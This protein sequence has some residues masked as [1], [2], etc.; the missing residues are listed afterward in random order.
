MFGPALRTRKSLNG[1]VN[2]TSLTYPFTESAIRTLSV[3]DAVSLNGLIYTGRDRL[4]KFLFDGGESPVDLHDGAIYHCG[5]VMAK[6]GRGWRVV[7]AGPTTSLREEPYM[8]RIIERCG[9]RVIIGKGGMGRATAEACQRLGCV[10]V[11]VV[12]GA[13][14]LLGQRVTA[15]RGVHFMDD[16]GAAEAM[17]ALDVEHIEG[18]VAM[19][20]QG[21]SLYDEVAT[22]SRMQLTR[23]LALRG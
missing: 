5:P 23:L 8:A 18:V 22:A 20:A 17:W 12:G 3:G 6:T 10:Y 14:V 9:V 13:A 4:H 7:A 19:D 21:R 16:F 11:Q 2:M 1:W 15:V